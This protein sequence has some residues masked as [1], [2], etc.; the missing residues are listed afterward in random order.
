ERRL[1]FAPGHVASLGRL[2]ELAATAGRPEAAAH[3]RT[4]QA[5]ANRARESYRDLLASRDPRGHA[6][7]LSRLAATLGLAF[8]S[9]RWAD[10]AGQHFPPSPTPARPRPPGETLADLLRDVAATPA[11]D[12]HELATPSEPLRFVDD[13]E[14]AGL[15][16]VHDTG[17]S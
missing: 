14:L 10:L 11:S 2:A 9:A 17:A 6:G 16:F 3:Y 1:E 13:A 12:H 7:E 15:R 8:E 4:L 5:E